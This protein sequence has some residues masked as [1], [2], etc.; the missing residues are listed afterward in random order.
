MA[1]E[2][3][4]PMMSPQA[5]AVNWHRLLF[6]GDMPATWRL[7]TEDFRRV[8]AQVALGKARAAGDDVD[9][10]VEGLAVA[11]PTQPY[12]GD[13]FQAAR[14]IMQRACVVAPDQVGAGVTTRFE[15]PAYEVV[16]LWVLEDLE[17]D[18]H[19]ERYLPDGARAM[20]LTLIARVEEPGTWRMAGIGN[21]SSPG[22]PPTVLWEPAHEV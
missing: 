15:A 1:D 10:V 19:G 4:T 7:M 6:A 21:V 8:I 20:G 2:T 22:W 12:V 16:R 3:D 11:A 9:P 17:V 13:L 14:Q 18:A 5:F